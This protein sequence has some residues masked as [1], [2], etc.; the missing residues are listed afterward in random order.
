MND[1][2]LFGHQHRLIQ[3]MFLDTNC[4]LSLATPKKFSAG[5]RRGQRVLFLT[6]ALMELLS[7]SLNQNRATQQS[8]PDPSSGSVSSDKELHPHS[9]EALIHPPQ[10]D[11]PDQGSDLEEVLC[12]FQ[13]QL[14]KEG[15]DLLQQNYD[16]SGPTVELGADPQQTD[17]LHHCHHVVP[18]LQVRDRV[19]IS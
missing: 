11:H 18:Q 6:R 3:F 10:D 14:D 4:V 17:L 7:W 13:Y 1:Q 19:S 2:E 9:G 12:V 8:W 5:V 16:P 15:A